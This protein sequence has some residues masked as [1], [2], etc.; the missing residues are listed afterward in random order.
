MLRAS[1]LVRS[2]PVFTWANRPASA[3]NTGRL[4]RISD[5]GNQLFISDGTY[6]LPDNGHAII[7]KGTTA[8][9]NTNSTSEFLFK[10]V[11]VPAGMPTPKTSL[12]VE[13]VWTLPATANSKI[14]RTRFSTSG[15]VG[16]GSLLVSAATNV[17][18]NLLMRD[19]RKIHNRNSL[20]SQ[21][22]NCQTG[23]FGDGWNGSG[24]PTMA[25]DTS[26][27]TYINYTGQMAALAETLT[28]ESYAVMIERS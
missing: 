9:S 12:I 23:W 13:Q 10:S 14:I 4:I 11:K 25:I 26:G 21:V 19:S 17:A 1:S 5:Y 3:N 27:D 2:L 6:W 18:T 15:S 16:T 24:L 22:V 20:S 28:L 7:E 8:I